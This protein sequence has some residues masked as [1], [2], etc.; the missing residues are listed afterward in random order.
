M[1]LETKNIFIN[2]KGSSKEDVIRRIGEIFSSQGCTD[3]SYTQA[4]LDKEKVFNTYIGNEIAIPHGI[5]EAKKYI[6]KTGLVLMTFPEGLDWGAS[7]KVRVVI[8]IAAVGDEH[9]EVLQKI[10]MTFSDK[11]GL[12]D[13]LKLNEEEISNLFEG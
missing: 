3:E 12:E 7:E 5:E 8:G 10:A 2:Q 11:Q 4:M 9:L 13:L 1:I 6:K